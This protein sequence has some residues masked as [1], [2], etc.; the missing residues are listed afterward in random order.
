MNSLCRKGDRYASRW[1]GKAEELWNRYRTERNKRNETS[2]L[3]WL[4]FRHKLTEQ[5]ASAKFLVLYTGSATDASAA[6]ID[7]SD[8][9]TSFVVDHKTYWCEVNSRLEGDY[10]CGYLNSGYAND[11]IKDLQ[12]RGPFGPRD[13]HTTITKLPFPS[14]DPGTL[15]D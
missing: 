8:F 2:F 13:I 3:D 7:C 1:F 5:N 6:M 12:S 9:S 4:D 15:F 10:L 11:K 14:F